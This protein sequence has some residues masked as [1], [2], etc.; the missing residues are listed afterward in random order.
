MSGSIDSKFA[1][2]QHIDVRDNI[3]N[4]ELIAQIFHP[5]N[6]RYGWK[7]N[8]SMGAN[9][10]HWNSNFAGG[11]TAEEEMAI[12][13]G[14]MCEAQTSQFIQSPYYPF[15]SIAKD[16]FKSSRL[17]RG[18]INGYT[19]GTDAYIHR[20]IVDEGLPLGSEFTMQTVMFYLNKN[21][22]PNYGGET[23][24][25]NSQGEICRSVLPK[26]GRVVCFDAHIKHGARPLSRIFYGI[27]QVLVLKTIKDNYPEHHALEVINNLTS[28]ISHSGSSLRNHL[29]GTYEIMAAL[30]FPRA[31]CLAG[32]FHS[33]YDTE[34]FQ[35]NLNISRK[36]VTDVIGVAAEALVHKFCTLRPRKNYILDPSN[37]KARELAMIEY[38]NLLEQ[39]ER[40]DITDFS[41]F[42]ALRDMLGQPRYISDTQKEL[43]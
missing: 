12:A 39:S 40:I 33:V 43:A 6:F 27:R 29:I 10:G 30:G 31:A 38:A 42:G 4:A 2:E 19:F 25:L 21:W 15:W 22:N 11:K 35:T 28:N 9:Q 18:Y 14:A 1:C 20:D 5:Q 16:L 17:T 37:P 23:V 8:T 13:K 7:S 36:E 41:Y 34:Y 3:G 26:E 24:F 32:L